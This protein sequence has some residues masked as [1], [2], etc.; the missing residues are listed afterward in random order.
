MT[1][2]GRAGA[3]RRY[4]STWL[5]IGTA[6]SFAI[7]LLHLG[8]IPVG[9]P[10]YAFFTAGEAIVTLAERGSAIPALLAFCLAVVFAAFG[11]YG[12]AA[13]GYLR[14]PATRLLIIVIGCVY[15][16]RGSLIVP[17]AIL[18][19]HLGYPG[20]ALVFSAIALIVGVA[21]LVGTFRQWP[22]IPAAG[23]IREL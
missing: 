6:A 15:T 7:A 10:A 18:V 19:T 14:L 22:W 8:M 12:L 2:A 11:L 21:H 13:L 9:A 23:Q 16:L 3:G 5:A 20:R 17:E 4:R 1:E